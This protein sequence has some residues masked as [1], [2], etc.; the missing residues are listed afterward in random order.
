MQ[1]QL[2]EVDFDNLTTFGGLDPNNP[3]AIG[4]TPNKID[5]DYTADVN[6]EFV[7]GLDRE[8]MQDLGVGVA[9][10]WRRS[11]NIEWY[12]FI[13][14]TSADYELGEPVTTNGYTSVPYVLR[15]G[16]LDRTDVTGGQILENHNDYQTTYKG[17][18]SP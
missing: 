18:E 5:P 16:V 3:G 6:Y 9:F 14:V 1:V 10:S 17:I 2:P 7:V 15:D 12:P 8:V 13:G 4:E 11:G